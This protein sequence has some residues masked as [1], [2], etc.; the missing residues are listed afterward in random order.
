MSI[1]TE[2]LDGYGALDPNLTFNAVGCGVGCVDGLASNDW[3]RLSHATS[4]A[5]RPA[6]DSTV[7]AWAN[8]RASARSVASAVT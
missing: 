7:H 4:S 2:A 8:P 5:G 6:A 3:N 1:G